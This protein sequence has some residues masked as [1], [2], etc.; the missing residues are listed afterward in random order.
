MLVELNHDEEA[1]IQCSTS[2]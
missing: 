2:A 1:H